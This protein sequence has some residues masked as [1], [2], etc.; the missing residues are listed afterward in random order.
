[1]LF[2][3]LLFSSLL[4]FGDEKKPFKTPK[5]AAIF[6]QCQLGGKNHLVKIYLL[7]L[8][9]RLA[10]WIISGSGHQHIAFGLEFLDAL[11]FIPN[12]KF[13]TTFFFSPSFNIFFRIPQQGTIT[14][15]NIT[16]VRTRETYV[17]VYLHLVLL[18]P[19]QVFIFINFF[20]L[21]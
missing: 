19:Q 8:C 20:L 1:M 12:L 10:G 13:P 5:N 7:P 18:N 16:T 14:T 2:S 3:S 17:W 11:I 4:N 15:W 6:G 21:F 9:P